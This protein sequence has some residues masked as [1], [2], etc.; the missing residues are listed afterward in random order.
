MQAGRASDGAR[1]VVGNLDD[2]A[3][4]GPSG[5]GGDGQACSPIRY[6]DCRANGVSLQDVERVQH[7]PKQ[8]RHRKDAKEPAFFAHSILS[9][10]PNVTIATPAPTIQARSRPAVHRPIGLSHRD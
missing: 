8:R 5:K 3:G 9:P 7:Q 10:Q 2:E 4:A 1:C 6:R